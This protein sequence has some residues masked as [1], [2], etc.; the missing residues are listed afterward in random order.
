MRHSIRTAYSL[1]R[2][3]ILLSLLV[4]AAVF[5]V[6]RVSC[7]AANWIILQA[8]T[9]QRVI[10]QYPGVM[11]G[12]SVEVVS[13]EIKDVYRTETELDAFFRENAVSSVYQIFWSE[14]N[15]IPIWFV[16]G[17]PSLVSDVQINDHEMH[18]FCDKDHPVNREIRIKDHAYIPETADLSTMMS[19]L[20]RS[21]EDGE[22]LVAVCRGI[23]EWL[24][25]QDV[26][27]PEADRQYYEGI[28]ADL[29]PEMIGNTLVLYSDRE[30]IEELKRIAGESF[31]YAEDTLHLDQLMDSI[32]SMILFAILVIVLFA[33]SLVMI[34]RDLIRSSVNELAILYFYGG[35]LREILAGFL[36]YLL[37]LL[38]IPAYLVYT[39][40]TM[41]FPSWCLAGVYILMLAVSGVYVFFL[42][43]RTDFYSVIK[44]EVS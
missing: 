19:Y 4:M 32:Q 13:T 7:L 1:F 36:L 26:N 11:T 44:G 12:F 15:E 35:S 9:Y 16:C 31:M 8:Q 34:L 39:I 38:I 40:S 14:D 25:V 27:L 18:V 23:P 6:S 28:S 42:L 17:D 10:H 2:R 37:S 5:C 41:H 29:L 21:R 20:R 24:R 3:R 22:I 43:K 33:S 30:K